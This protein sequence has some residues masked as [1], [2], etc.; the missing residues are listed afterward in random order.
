MPQVTEP[1]DNPV[2]TKLCD[3]GLRP[4]CDLLTGLLQLPQSLIDT[5]VG[6]E[7]IGELGTDIETLTREESWTPVEYAATGATPQPIVNSNAGGRT[8]LTH[9]DVL[10]LYRVLVWLRNQMAGNP[11]LGPLLHKFAV[12]PRQR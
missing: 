2:L 7:L 4:V 9:H 3:E 11:Q 5:L 12:N 1:I 6:K 10:A 8:T